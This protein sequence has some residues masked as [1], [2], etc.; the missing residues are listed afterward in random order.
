MRKNN[1]VLLATVLS[2]VIRPAGAA[3]V[4]NPSFESDYNT[5]WPHY[6]TIDS[7]TATG[8]EGVNDST[9]PFHN[10]GAAIP[11]R[12]RVA[13][14]QDSQL[15]SQGISGLTPGS[16]YWI[17][18]YYNA[19]NCCGGTMDLKV[20]FTDANGTTTVL[21]TIPNVPASTNAYTFRN[22]TFTPDTDTG[23]LIF[24]SVATGDATVDLDAVSM[25]QRDLGNVVVAN[26]SFEASGPPTDTTGIPPA[27][28]SGEIFS[29]A[30]MAGWL[31]DTNQTGSYGISLVGG[32]YAD[33]G[34]IPDQ[35]LVA[36]LQGPGSLSQTVSGLFTGTVYQV[37]F[38]YNAQAAAGS[39]HLQVSVNGTV[40]DDESVAPVGGT[41]P[42]HTKTVSFTATQ[43]NATIAF[44]Q[45]AASGVL[46]LDDVRVTGKVRTTLPLQFSPQSATLHPTQT[47]TVAVTVPP[48]L[49]AGQPADLKFSMA[50][51]AIARLVN[52]D[53]NGQVTLHYTQGGTNVQTLQIQAVATGTT[54]LNVDESA[55]LTVP[56][57]VTI[58]V[59]SSFV[60]NPSFEDSAVPA[61]PGYGAIASWT[62]SAGTGLNDKTGT[63]AD[64]GIIPDRSQVAFL[65]NTSMLSQVIYGLVPGQTYWLQFR[66]NARAS[67]QTAINL[68]VL[69]G[70]KTL[71]A[72]PN[73]TAVGTTAGD[74]PFYFINI[75]F[76]PGNTNSGLLTFSTSPTVMGTDAA[77]LLDAVNIVQRGANDVVIENPSFEASG[78]PVGVGYC[79][80]IDGWTGI[81]GVNIGSIHEGPFTD[82]GVSPDQDAVGFIQGSLTLSQTLTNV[83]VGQVYTL[84]YAVN[85]RTG[86]TSLTYDVAFGDLQLLTGQDIEPVGG[87]NPYIQMYL[88][89]TNDASSGALTFTP[90]PVGDCTLLLDNIRLVPGL[91]APTFVSQPVSDTNAVIGDTVTFTPGVGGS[92]P[93][94]YQWSKNGTNL[95]GATDFTL[96]LTNVTMA[97]AGSYVLAVTNAAGG[98][99]SQPAFLAVVWNVIPGVFGTGVAA[100]GTL[101]SQGDTDPHYILSVSADTNY[102]GPAAIVVNNAWPIQAG[103]WML[104]GPN[105]QWIAPQADQ[106]TT[107]GNAEGDYT[108]ETSFDLTGYP[109]SKVQIVGGW[110]VDNTG[111]NILVNGVSSGLT[112][113]GFGSLTPFT[114]TS[115]N[116]LV[117]GKNILDFMVNNLPVTPNATGLRVD[118]RALLFMPPTLQIH[119]VGGNVVISWVPYSTSQ[120]LLSA[121]T[122]SGPWTSITPLPP[123]SYTNKPSAGKTFYRVVQTGQ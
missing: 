23:T 37:S 70:G 110:A 1:L 107:A 108:Y 67:G 34:A 9:G 84:I 117:A 120:S 118:L 36:V 45:T 79:S 49:L 93:L 28:D 24:A 53:T 38:A 31:W 65:Q 56:A 74:V 87:D 40:V 61:S 89:F 47:L 111:K 96:V 114:L 14:L 46:L 2:L 78:F 91:V 99:K 33:N 100:D 54:K 113:P 44:A 21:D 66:Y 64:N 63:F 59:I 90:H 109:I 22:V 83:V 68:Q 27:T 122:V 88:S 6:S 116:G 11:D 62:G 81:S 8:G 97:D 42:Y 85:R 73:I 51:P 69:F 35:D 94:T 20:E 95:A 12:D 15:L 29:P 112:C 104:D 72:I 121:P 4:A 123:G 3:F 76:A 50:N 106:G 80:P 119:L 58:T 92:P 26:P 75:P 13:F 48:A 86:G 82:N 105:S 30:N 10:T 32:V 102:P 7:W 39:A 18:F 60:L 77:L 16:Q 43:T 41:N 103:V 101:L 19:R 115:A 17:Q 25:V 55:G 57:V 52:A 71:A 5:T 98:V